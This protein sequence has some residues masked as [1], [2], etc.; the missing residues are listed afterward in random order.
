[1]L[2][3]W[4]SYRYDTQLWLG[5]AV[6]VTNYPTSDGA[7]FRLIDME[8]LQMFRQVL[9]SHLFHKLFIKRIRRQNGRF[10]RDKNQL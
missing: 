3:Q 1:M 8:L 7:I 9:S 5:F 10:Y 2:D 6:A 4:V